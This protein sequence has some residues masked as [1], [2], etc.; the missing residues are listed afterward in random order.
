VDYL[1]KKN[2]IKKSKIVIDI[3]Q[4][5]VK[6][7]SVHYE[8]GKISIHGSAK[9][10][11]AACFF[12][13]ELSDIKELVKKIDNALGRK[14]MNRS[15]EISLSIPSYMGVQKIVA[16]KNVKPKDLDKHIKKEYPTIGKATSVTHYID[17]AYLGQREIGG[18]TVQYCMLA[19]VSKAHLIPIL[20]EFEKRKLKVTSVTFPTY[21]LVDLSDLYV[22]DYEHQNK[23]LVDFG[24]SQTRVVVECEGVAVYAREIDIGFNTFADSLF[25]SFPS[26]GVPEIVTMLTQM[27]IREENFLAGLHD[28][29]AFF[30]VIDKLSGDMQ[31]ELIRI[32]QMCDEDG[33]S[34]TKIICASGVIDGLFNRFSENGIEVE[35]YSFETSERTSGSTFTISAQD[36]AG[37]ISADFGGA[38]G[39]AVSTLH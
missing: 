27:G 4:K 35:Q 18:E 22:N 8:K 12:E 28:K 19:A 24:M 38:V 14:K 32:I 34:I 9:I 13:G 16:I 36:E 23:M 31:N 7:L 5:F 2:I 39:I 25:N 29:D 33:C 17:W 30:A 20:S 11:S 6:I 26:I 10:D 15:S 37:E 21:N 1:V 3:G